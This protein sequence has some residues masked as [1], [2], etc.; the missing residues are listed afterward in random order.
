MM[1]YSKTYGL[2]R[3]YLITTHCIAIS[4][5]IHLLHMSSL[6]QS[7]LIAV[8]AA[9]ML[10]ETI[11]M[12]RDMQATFPNI[13]G[14][15]RTIRGLASKW[16]VRLSDPILQALELSNAPTLPSTNPVTSPAVLSPAPANNELPSPAMENDNHAMDFGFLL[17][18]DELDDMVGFD[19]QYFVDF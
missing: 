10:L 8:Q 4:A 16:A 2:K 6:E 13:A 3:G 14:Y 12:M 18:E 19:T 15:L 17:D 1:T 11:K 9:D 5:I 7:L